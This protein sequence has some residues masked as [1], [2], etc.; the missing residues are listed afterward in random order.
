MS[1]HGHP[2]S[3]QSLCLEIAK[4]LPAK[5]VSDRDKLLT[6]DFWT[7]LFTLIGTKLSMSTVNHAKTDGQTEAHNK[8]IGQLLRLYA[9]DDQLNWDTYLPF[10]QFAMNNSISSSTGVTPF[11]ANHAQH[12]W[13]PAYLA[14]G[15]LLSVDNPD[16]N[17]L[18][19]RIASITQLV[20]DNISVA[21]DRQ[22]AA[23]NKGRR[24]EEFKAGDLVWV[25]NELNPPDENV[26]GKFQRGFQGPYKIEQ[27]ING[28]AYRLD[29]KGS[30]RHP[31]I[32]V[33]FLKRHVPNDPEFISRS[34]A[35]A[36]ADDRGHVEIEK[37]LD[38]RIRYGKPEYKVRWKGHGAGNEEWLKLENLA[39]AADLVREFDGR[40]QRTTRSGGG[41]V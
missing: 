12:P 1:M 28:N 14:A 17:A 6:S 24:G 33:E 3:M 30:R 23:A 13:L 25:S 26:T 27:K 8:T 20:K 35:P 16:V 5:I 38:K 2:K 9:V 34:V 4:G 39:D 15:L 22:A 31:V 7:T 18:T 32:N 21:Q 36:P 29:L 10:V 37:L 11:Y 41:K 19:R 40:F